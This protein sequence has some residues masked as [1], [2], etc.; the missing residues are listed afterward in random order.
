MATESCVE[1]A[2]GTYLQV[3]PSHYHLVSVSVLNWWPAQYV[4]R[5][6]IQIH[7]LTGERRR[8]LKRALLANV[9]AILLYDCNIIV[10]THDFILAHETL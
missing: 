6:T 7:V 2:T 9:S 3:S 4:Y 1:Q 8:E 10:K 5:K